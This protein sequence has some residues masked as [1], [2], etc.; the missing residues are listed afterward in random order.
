LADP[1]ATKLQVIKITEREYKDIISL[2]HD[3]EV[4][5]SDAPETING[6]YLAQVCAEGWGVY[7][8]FLVNL[9]EQSV[10]A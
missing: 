4:G 3:H 10:S 7:K 2:L 9:G 5:D 1:L 6:A 8:T